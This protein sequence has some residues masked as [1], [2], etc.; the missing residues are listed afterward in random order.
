MM[1][2][3]VSLPK[4]PRRRTH[5]YQSALDGGL[6][7]LVLLLF[8]KSCLRLAEASSGQEKSVHKHMRQ[9][10]RRHEESFG[11]GLDASMGRPPQR[12]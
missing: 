2:W 6:F 12:G 4:C 8:R 10:A 11:F 7:E 9:I 3:F 1:G 5:H